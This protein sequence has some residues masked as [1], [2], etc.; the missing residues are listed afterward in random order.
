MRANSPSA[1][2]ASVMLH[3]LIAVAIA[4]MTIL[5]SHREQT[6]PVIFELVRGEPIEGAERGPND[7]DIEFNLPKAKPQPRPTPPIRETVETPTPPKPVE[8]KVETKKPSPKPP[9]KEEKTKT[10]VRDT[11]KMSYEEFVKKHGKPEPKVSTKPRQTKT[12][13]VDTSKITSSSGRPM[14]GERGRAESRTEADAMTLY[15]ANLRDRLKD[16]HDETKPAGLGD[17]VSAEVSFFLAANGRIQDV[18]IVRSS[19]HPEFDQSVLEA[20]RRIAWSGAR[21]DKRGE[22]MRLTFRM[23]EE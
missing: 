23:Q 9:P 18:R 12:P 22:M 11:A 15:L 3:G 7:G 20:F 17:T 1:F 2:L 8:K 21:P 16:A 19:G 10:P 6:P 14:S 5:V 13:R 4:L